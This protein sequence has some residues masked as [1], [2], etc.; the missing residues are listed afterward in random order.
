MPQLLVTILLQIVGKLLGYGFV[1]RVIVAF[2]ELWA[3][4]TK[5]SLDDKVFSAIA[6]SLEVDSKVLKSLAASADEKDAAAVKVE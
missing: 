2:L 4:S 3:K 1:C 5:T 6:D